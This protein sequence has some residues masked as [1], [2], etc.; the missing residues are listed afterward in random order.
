[1]GIFRKAY[2]AGCRAGMAP[3]LW[4]LRRNGTKVIDLPVNPYKGRWQCFLRTL[5]EFGYDDELRKR[6]LGRPHA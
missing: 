1:M 3:P 6:V 4:R 2:G 5:W